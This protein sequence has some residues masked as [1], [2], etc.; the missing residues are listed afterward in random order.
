MYMSLIEEDKYYS[1][2]P[3][4]FNPLLWLASTTNEVEIYIYISS[5]SQLI[6]HLSL[7]G[8]YR[9]SKI[10]ISLGCLKIQRC[11]LKYMY[12]YIYIYISYSMVCQER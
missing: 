7:M 10:M 12:I 11:K 5:R 2:E 3:T 8:V 4:T 6:K 1:L 9:G